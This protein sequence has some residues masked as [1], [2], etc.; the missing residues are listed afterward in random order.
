MYRMI[1]TIALLILILL[2]TSGCA[3]R[4]PEPQIVYLP[5][6]C[7]IPTV[8]EPTIDNTSYSEPKD[9]VAKALTNY[10]KM[11]EYTEKL[12]ASQVVCK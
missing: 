10:T 1:A 7:V 11:K 2:I 4:Q 3:I 6:R 5:Q 12:L 8:E 9:I